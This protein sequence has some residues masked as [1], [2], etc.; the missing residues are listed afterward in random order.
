MV[1]YDLAIPMREWSEELLAGDAA[2]L[3]RERCAHLGR[4]TGVDPRPIWEWGFVERVS[5]GLFVTQ[6]GADRMG[7]EMLDVAEA[8]LES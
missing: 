3:G 8:W 6:V 4:L 7:R 1:Y 2:R 5:T